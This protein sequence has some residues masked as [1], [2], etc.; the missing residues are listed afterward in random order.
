MRGGDGEIEAFG[1][2]DNFTRSRETFNCVGNCRVRGNVNCGGR[3]LVD[4]SVDVAVT[5]ATQACL[6]RSRRQ[7]TR[8]RISARL[9]LTLRA[10]TAERAGSKDNHKYIGGPEE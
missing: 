8:C 5:E 6:F 4:L 2:C 9:E 1:L 3:H 7:L 10:S